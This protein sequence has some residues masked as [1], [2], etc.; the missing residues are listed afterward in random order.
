MHRP[1]GTARCTVSPVSSRARRRRARPCRPER[2]QLRLAS[3]TRRWP[4]VQL[5]APISTKPLGVSAATIRARWDA[6]NRWPWRSRRCPRARDCPPPIAARMNL[7]NAAVPATPLSAVWKRKR[8]WRKTCEE[9]DPRGCG[10]ADKES[11]RKGGQHNPRPSAREK[12]R[13]ATISP[14][15]G[16]TTPVKARRRAQE[17]RRPRHV[18]RDAPARQRRARRMGPARA[19][20]SCSA[21]VSA[22]RSSRAPPR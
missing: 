4:S 3:C 9:P 16:S 6:E 17:H 14:S 2:L 19:G 1:E 21:W 18:L 5:V 12:G 22:W 13:R 11:E 15:T 20:S 10:R 7:E 8:A